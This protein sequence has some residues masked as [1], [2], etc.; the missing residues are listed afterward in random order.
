M[1][2][3]FALERI[4][5]SD[6]TATTPNSPFLSDQISKEPFL[7]SLVLCC[8]DCQLGSI[9]I[10]NRT[11]TIFVILGIIS[12]LIIRGSWGPTCLPPLCVVWA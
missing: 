9:I 3:I 11:D 4:V 5:F 10:R 12:F 8:S 2:L 6:M 7:E 1:F